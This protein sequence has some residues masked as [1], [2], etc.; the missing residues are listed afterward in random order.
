M[1]NLPTSLEY[2]LF[3]ATC[4][5]FLVLLVGAEDLIE[6]GDASLRMGR[7]V[8]GDPGM[9]SEK[10]RVGVEGWNFCN[11]VGYEASGAPS[12]RWADCTDINCKSVGIGL[13]HAVQSS[14]SFA[15]MCSCKHSA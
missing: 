14:H 11:R 6:D 10:V 2:G 3:F 12:P 1:R 4:V 7:S 15:N 9:K 5:W 13:S 8:L